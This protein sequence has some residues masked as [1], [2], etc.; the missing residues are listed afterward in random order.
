MAK[1]LLVED[2]TIVQHVHKLIF[3]KL[4]HTVEIVDSG[5]K[6]LEILKNK[7]VYDIIFVDI[8]LPDIKGFDLIKEIRSSLIQDSNYPI[9]ALTGYIGDAEKKSCL[10]AG[11]TEVLH[12]PI[13]L[14]TMAD[15]L[16]R[17][18]INN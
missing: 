7:H 17:Y 9:I 14:N 15:T 6:A 1:I 12:K 4:G 2:N 11:A 18:S 10:E 8:G 13:L 3:N 5:F 16:K